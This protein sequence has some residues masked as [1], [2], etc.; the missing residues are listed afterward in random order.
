MNSPV[1]IPVVEK[2][3]G[4]G[5]KTKVSTDAVVDAV[6]EEKP[7]AKGRAKKVVA[8][9]KSDSDA[10]ADADADAA[11][12]D[13]D[14][15][16]KN[17]IAKHAL[18]HAFTLHL[19]KTSLDSGLFDQDLFDRFLASQSFF[20]DIPSL[21]NL[22]LLLD[23]KNLLKNAKNARKTFEK[24][25]TAK[26]KKP[27]AKKEKKGTD[28]PTD[29]ISSLVS[30][31]SSKEPIVPPASPENT[32]KAVEEPGSPVKQKRKYTRKPKVASVAEE[33]AAAGQDS[34]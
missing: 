5:R 24:N 7:K 30:L 15:P 2:T 16:R 9:E 27:R 25:A 19:A 4:R 28:E 31:A 12:G 34:E 8:Q 13:A 23:F 22:F 29:L 21:H 26:E 32:M 6:V 10:D 33:L 17:L 1:V 3:K 20:L 11:P 18:L 14:K